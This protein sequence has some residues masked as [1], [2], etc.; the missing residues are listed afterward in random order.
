VDSDV[1]PLLPAHTWDTSYR[2]EDGDLVRLFYVPALSC[3]VQYD[4][5]TGYFSADALVL[6]ARGIERLVANGGKMRLIVGCTLEADEVLAIGEGYDLRDQVEKKLA[7]TP[8]TPPDPA[9]KHGLESLACMVANGSLDVKVAVPIDPEGKPVTVQGIYHEKVG[10]IADREGNRLSFSGSINET[11]GGW[12]NNRESFHVH[13]SWEG[14]RDTQHVQDEV[15]SFKRLWD[16]HAQSVKVI[17][18]PAALKSKLLE[19]LPTDD[20]FVTPP[21]APKRKKPDATPPPVTSPHFLLPDEVR[22]VVWTYIRNAAR[23]W[24]GLTVGE[25]TSTVTP[26]PHQVR[27]YQKLIE[28]WPCQM[29]IADEVGLGKTITAGLFIR[30]AWLSGRAKRILILMPRSLLTQ[31]QAELYEKFNLNVPIYDGQKLVWKRT[32]GWQG[33]AERKVK[34]HEWHKEPFVLASSQLMRRGDRSADLLQ[35]EDWDLLVLD[36]A[37][38]ARRKSPGTPQEGG[39][40]QLLCLMHQLRPKSRSL[41]LLSATPMQVHPVELWDLLRLLGLTGRWEASRDDFIRYFA[42]AVGNPGQGTMEYLAGMFRETEA[43]FGEV[44]EPEISRLLPSLGGIGC[45]KVLRALRD[46]SGIPLK[47]LDVPQR[48][49]ALKLLRRFSPVRYRMVRH[50]RNLLREYHRRGLIDTPIATRD[51]RDVAFDMTG[52]EK[53]MYDALGDYID[54][55]YNNASPEKRSAVGFVLTIYQRRLASSFYALQQTLS[56]RLANMGGITEEDLSQDETSDEVMDAE[57]AEALARESLADEERTTVRDLLKKIA[58]IGNNTKART[59]KSELDIAFADGYD[60]AIIFTQYADTMD[61]L[62]EHL[63]AEFPDE[64]IACYSG[65]GGKVRDRAGFWTECSKEQIKQ[66][67]K[68]RAIK[69]LVCTDAAAEGL[70]FQFCGLLVNYDLPW[71]PMKVEQRIGRIDRIGQRFPKIRVINLAYLDTVEADVYFALGKRINLFEGMV[72]RLQPILSRLPKQ[73][74]EVALEKKENREAARHRLM[75]EVETTARATDQTTLDID[76]VAADSLELPF[77]PAPAL[78]LTDLDQALNRPNILPPGTEWRRLDAGSYALRVPGMEHEIRVTT[79]AE[80]FD[81][82]FESHEFLSPGGSLFE[83]IVSECLT[84]GETAKP[85]VDGRIWL[86]VDGRTNSYRILAR[87]RG[88]IS[89][90]NSLADLLEAVSDG[91]SAAPFDMS[92]MISTEELSLLA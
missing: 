2:H 85:A 23:A 66:R 49:A 4:R 44:S 1:I 32:H 13:L 71:N 78:T 47:R 79:Q 19:F 48:K 62:K 15:E 21:R 63:A 84:D 3:A 56:K 12:V 90:C 45:R 27:T 55:T 6:A 69:F 88:E 83:R 9:A 46:K 53:A 74:E 29:L 33:P 43:S 24:N 70:N 41:L 8:I 11:A 30:Q 36:E 59:L 42:Q 67:L 25:V 91:S 54:Q 64:M 60:S 5:M 20:R 80:V 89:Q 87:R 75:A 82:H 10:I 40:N 73:F 38:H 16:G 28:T 51:V 50:T 58:K 68:A 77:V 34:R 81:D 18:F 37:H 7:A 76:E 14:G 35:A 17:D 22:R 52:A 65:A 72:G 57:E 61:F 26:W 31:W 39:P 92:L 86:V